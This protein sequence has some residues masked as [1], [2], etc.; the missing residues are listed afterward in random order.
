MAD[1]IFII[2][3]FALGACVGSFINVIVWRLP[4]GQS[5]VRPPSHCPQCNT[6]LAWYD[7]IPVLG[8]IALGGRCRY[9]RRPIS[10]RYPMVEAFTGG[11]F[12]LYYAAMFIWN[13]GPCADRPMSLAQDWP[14]YFLYMTML[15]G[16]LASSLIDAEYL[17]IPI[18]IPW[19]ITAVALVVHAMI[20]LPTVPGSLSVSPPVGAMAAGAG[21]GLV[22]S[23]ILLRLGVVP[24]S[25]ADETTPEIDGP[26]AT[27]EA[28]SPE[29]ACGR[30]RLEIGKEMLF[31]LPPLLLGGLW[32]VICWKVGPIERMWR[33][34]VSHD[35]ASGFLGSLWG[36]LVGAFVVWL[37][38]IVGSITFGREAMGMGDVHLMLG[39]GAVIG[40]AGAVVVF[41]IAPCIGL[42]FGLYKLVLRRGREVPYGP[43]LSMAAALV[44][45]FYCPII[46][47]LMPSTE[48]L[49]ELLRRKLAGG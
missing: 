14:I 1:L 10:I 37:T 47:Y 41:F 48:A 29:P 32:L 31:L 17:I 45:L 23:I 25:F 16:L 3:L 24:Q 21:A 15:S 12:A 9:C 35:W 5:I 18:E 40:A 2:F 38:R 46:E 7:N 28:L 22:I 34:V 36:A 43:F 49:M 13:L 19:I 30:I 20:G 6:P 26:A 11:L 44:M 4:R 33:G 42:I 8:W 39:I 27:D